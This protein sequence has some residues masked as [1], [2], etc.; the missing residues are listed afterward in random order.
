MRFWRRAAVVSTGLIIWAAYC[1]ADWAELASHPRDTGHGAEK[2]ATDPPIANDDLGAPSPPASDCASPPTGRLA[3]WLGDGPTAPQ[4][5]SDPVTTSPCAFLPADL[6]WLRWHLTPRPWRASGVTRNDYLDAIQGEVGYWSRF[7][8]PDGSLIDPYQSGVADSGPVT[9]Y[10]YA[11]ATL[12]SAGRVEQ[13]SSGL[14]VMDHAT[15]VYLSNAIPGPRGQVGTEF[16]IAPLVEA[17]PLLAP[18]ASPAQVGAWRTSMSKTYGWHHPGNWA[19]I[20]MRGEWLQFRAGLIPHAAAVSAIEDAWTRTQNDPSRFSDIWGLY[21]DR[22]SNP[23]SLSVEAVGRGNLFALSHEGYDGPS[24]ARLAETTAKG[25]QTALLLQDPN[26]QAPAGGR[27][28]DHVWVDLAYGSN[29]NAQAGLT[30]DPWLAGQF[31]RAANLA[32]LSAQ[33]WR[34]DDGAYQVTKNFFDPSRRVGYQA[35]SRFG[36]YNGA[37]MAQLSDSYGMMSRDIPEQP[38]PAEI[39]GYALALTDGFHAAFADAGGLQ[40]EIGLEGETAN[41]HGNRWSVLGIVRISRSGWDARLGPSDGKQDPKTSQAISF[42]PTW[43]EAGKWVTLGEMAGRYRGIFTTTFANPTLVIAQVIWTPV[44]GEIGPVFRQDLTLTPDGILSR[45]RQIR[46]G[47]KFGIIYPILKDDGRTSTIQSLSNGTAQVSF[48]KNGDQ[49]NYITLN[50]RGIATRTGRDVETSYGNV[51]PMRVVTADP[52]LDSFIYPRGPADPSAANLRR[53]FKLTG[54]GYVSP[55]GRVS[56]T[57]YVGR[58]AAGGYGNRVDL[59][60]DGQAD[61]IFARNCNFVLQLSAGKVTALETD[62]AVTARVQGQLLA[63]PAHSPVHL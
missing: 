18:L 53:G 57:L 4:S 27:T 24:A 52:E 30:A 38:T 36:P 55:I 10:P 15:D 46:G 60:G 35:A 45:L 44:A 25:G 34:R 59:D 31:R 19:A 28:S 32:F 48:A 62:S 43:R 20:F 61:V 16:W 26:G 22:S 23:D 39:G 63:L 54:D 17:I 50:R 21:H 13:L 8:G 40:L 1:Q 47:A 33:R 5:I 41:E 11:V 3:A 12:A 51:T 9:A 7:V 56:G 6:P 2:Q 14:K 37:V 49:Q 58:Y 42:A 29:M